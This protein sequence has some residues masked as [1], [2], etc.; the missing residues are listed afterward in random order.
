M[1]SNS[2]TTKPAEAL[3]SKSVGPLSLPKKIDLCLLEEDDEFEEFP[4]EECAA[5]I[6]EPMRKAN[7]WDDNWDD[8][9]IES[10]FCQQLKN[11]QNDIP[12]AKELDKNA[13][14]VA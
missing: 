7:L 11:E 4:A 13:T 12:Y 6:D 8:D 3:P 14:V 10:D 5:K 9:N 1:A 2:R